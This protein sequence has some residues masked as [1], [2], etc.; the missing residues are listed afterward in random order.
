MNAATTT[1]PNSPDDMPAGW[2]AGHNLRNEILGLDGFPFVLITYE[3]DIRHSNATGECVG[4]WQVEIHA[5]KKI[6]NA[7]HEDLRNALW[8]VTTHAHAADSLEYQRRED[9]KATALAKLNDEEK[10]LLGL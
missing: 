10:R 2:D 6:F 8:F 7:S 3:M 9:A 5:R 1:L 4:K